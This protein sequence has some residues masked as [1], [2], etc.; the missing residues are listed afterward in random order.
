M[1]ERNLPEEKSTMIDRKAK[2][3]KRLVALILQGT[4]IAKELVIFCC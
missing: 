4:S 1:L 3:I 2:E